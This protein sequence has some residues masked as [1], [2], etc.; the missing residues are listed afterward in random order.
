MWYKT[1]LIPLTHKVQQQDQPKAEQFMTNLF[2]QEIFLTEESM[3]AGLLI[4]LICTMYQY[5]GN[6]EKGSAKLADFTRDLLGL[7]LVYSKN[8]YDEAIGIN[9]FVLDADMLQVLNYQNTTPKELNKELRVLEKEILIRLNYSMRTDF[10]LFLTIITQKEFWHLRSAI[11][12]D[13]QYLL[14]LDDGEIFTGFLA[15]VRNKPAA[16]QPVARQHPRYLSVKAF[17]EKRVEESDTPRVAFE[18][19]PCSSSGRRD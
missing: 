17:W 16:M 3:P 14:P 12:D 15:K 8:F 1:L 11:E 18:T 10:D 5:Y 19:P 2:Q 7:S 9:N 4:N 6:R 13:W